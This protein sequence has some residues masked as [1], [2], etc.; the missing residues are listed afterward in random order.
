MYDSIM[1][2][3]AVNA[4]KSR[5][6]SA[7]SSRNSYGENSD[8]RL[9]PSVSAED[10]QGLPSYE[11]PETFNFEHSSPVYIKNT[12]IETGFWQPCSFNGFCDARAIQSCPA[13]LISAP[14]SL[15]A[16]A[17]DST[18]MLQQSNIIGS[19][20]C[21]KALNVQDELSNSTMCGF[22]DMGISKLAIPASLSAVNGGG[23]FGVHD[24]GL[25]LYANA[26]NGLPDYDYQAPSFLE[27]DGVPA[28]AIK[29]TFIDTETCESPNSCYEP[30][31]IMSCPASGIGEFHGL[32]EGDH[33]MGK[34][35]RRAVTIDSFATVAM[36]AAAPEEFSGCTES[37]VQPCT[38][39]CWPMCCPHPAAEVP[40][41]PLMLEQ[42][43]PQAMGTDFCET[44]PDFTD[45]SGSM[46]ESS[47]SIS[48]PQLPIPPAPAQTRVLR[49]SDAL[50]LPSLGSPQLP[51]V[52]SAGHCNGTCKPCIHVD[53]EA[54]CKNGV[55]CLFCHLCPPGELKRRQQAKKA[56]K[57]ALMQA[58][59]GPSNFCMRT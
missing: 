31:K 51:T 58:L 24:D 5:S 55:Q 59:K 18:R 48:M 11:Y 43:L 30:R 25:S 4:A 44:F 53:K 35:T 41:L 14:R 3:K 23:A 40:V 7:G 2:K 42:Y 15:Q 49:L 22:G 12:F 13:D 17:S 36:V 56:N 20:A 52:G 50:S 37:V 21:T 8:H 45:H 47:V 33:E 16:D 26:E 19:E 46:L 9:T 38:G 54:G 27:F 32:K 1:C 6:T 39:A 57:S 29:N 10:T 28:Y 34:M